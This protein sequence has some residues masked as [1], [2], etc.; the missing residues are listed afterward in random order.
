MIIEIG[1]ELVFW[2]TKVN[3][4]KYKDH[5][6]T[7]IIRCIIQTDS[8][9]K[10]QWGNWTEPSSYSST[11]SRKLANNIHSLACDRSSKLHLLL[12]V[13]IH[14][15]NYKS[16]YKTVDGHFIWLFSRLK[17]KDETQW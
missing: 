4:V 9:E 15:M 2:K 14:R 3:S 12:I 16:N 8:L 5:A 7:V 13:Y 10:W 1:M 17:H 6:T 11:Q